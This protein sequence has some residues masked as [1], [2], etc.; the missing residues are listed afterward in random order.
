MGT[1]SLFATGIGLLTLALCLYLHI[2]VYQRAV[3]VKATGHPFYQTSRETVCSTGVLQYRSSKMGVPGKPIVVPAAQ[4]HL[5]QDYCRSSNTGLPRDVVGVTALSDVDHYEMAKDMMRSF[6]TCLPDL[7]LV[8]VDLGLP[9]ELAAE[10][11]R[12]CNVRYVRMDLG[13]YP[14]YVGFLNEFRFKPVVIHNVMFDKWDL[15]LR[16]DA[17]FWMDSSVRLLCR[18]KDNRKSSFASRWKAALKEADETGVAWCFPQGFISYYFVPD[19]ML[20]YLP[21]PS[22]SLRQQ[23]FGAG[24]TIFSKT[25]IHLD[26]IF[27]WW[28]G[29]ALDPNCFLD[30]TNVADPWFTGSAYIEGDWEKHKSCP[31]QP[32]HK[33]KPSIKSSKL[34]CSRTDQSALNLLWSNAHGR[35]R[36][37]P[38]IAEVTRSATHLY[39]ENAMS[40]C[41]PLIAAG[42]NK[43]TTTF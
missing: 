34:P 31:V 21:S 17:V 14:L 3:D 38:K 22:Y 35:H 19:S 18:H 40:Q 28:F 25:Q 11:K 23:M 36:G 39:N 2:S 32:M 41:Q 8:F 6:R 20:A 42:N 16:P 1:K 37:I 10:I 13:D 24:C 4:A 12:L 5:L 26:S 33:K 27:I 7:T 15:G 29:C 30:K 9:E 43:S